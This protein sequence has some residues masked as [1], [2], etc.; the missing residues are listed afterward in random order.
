MSGGDDIPEYRSRRVEYGYRSELGDHEIWADSES[1]L[2][3]AMLGDSFTWYDRE[4]MDGVLQIVGDRMRNDLT[5]CAEGEAGR[6]PTHVYVRVKFGQFEPR[7]PDTIVMY[8]LVVRE[9]FRREH[10]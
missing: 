6:L 1:G 5:L 9:T 10:G 4:R 7:T 2:A 8:K 3:Q